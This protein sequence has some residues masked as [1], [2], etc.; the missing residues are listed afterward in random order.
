MCESSDNLENSY[1]MINPQGEFQ[2]N[3]SG[4]YEIYDNCLEE[5]FCDILNRVP[6]DEDKF[7]ARYGKEWE[8]E[9]TTK[10]ICIFG[11][12]DT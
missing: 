5:E 8:T 7:D 10:R 6:I 11:G 1:L 9:A 4:K 12:H 2:L 3:N